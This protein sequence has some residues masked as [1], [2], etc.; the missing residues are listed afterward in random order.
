[1]NIFILSE[2]PREA[3]RM[4]CDKHINKMIIEAA[5]MLCTA[6]RMLDG[7]VERR[8]SK[9]GKRMVNYWVHPNSNLEATLYKAVHHHHPCTV[10]T[11]ETKSNYI[12]HYEHM[13]GLTDEFEHRYG[14]EHM[15]KLKLIDTLKHAPDNIKD[16]GLTPFAQAM[17]HYPDCK[18]EGDAVSAYRNYYHAAKD[19][20]V[21]NKGRPS[22]SWWQGYKGES[23][24]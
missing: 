8:A 18:V 22:P 14:K 9:S 12:W 17:S 20:A 3:A 10:W 5:Q 4:M 16:S 24:A 1:M 7:Q 11:M 15:T 23:W 13:V 6:H 19:F 2:E 21:W